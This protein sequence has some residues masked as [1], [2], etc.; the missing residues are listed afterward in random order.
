MTTT[1]VTAYLKVYDEEYDSTRKFENRLNHFILMLELGINIC[2]FIEPE[3]KDKFNEL[4]EQ[5][6]NLKIIGSMKIEELELY[7]IAHNSPELCNL[8]INRNNLKDT[9]EYMILM[10][11]KLEFIKRAIDV[12]PF[13]S[14]NF[15]WFDFSLPYV[16]HDTHNTLLKIQKISTLQFQEQFLYIPGCWNFKVYDIEYLKNYIA[17][18]FSGGFLIGDKETLIQFYTTSHDCFLNFLHQTNTIVWEVNYWAWLESSG[19]INPIWYLGIHDDSIV[20]IPLDI[21]IPVEYI[22]VEDIP[23]E[24]IPVEDIPVEDIPVEDISPLT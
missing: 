22:P 15:C 8:P 1:F 12:N 3:L 23:V 10:L 20:N 13:G 19:L 16:F 2:I 6:S 9:K 21:D 24:D 18:R 7:K 11:S 17:W 14:I 5:Y 4:E